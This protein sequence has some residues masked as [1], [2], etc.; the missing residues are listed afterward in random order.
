MTDH[1][2]FKNY[3]L[4]WKNITSCTTSWK[5]QRYNAA[6]P[7]AKEEYNTTEFSHFFFQDRLT[8]AVSQFEV[9]QMEFHNQV[10]NTGSSSVADTFSVLQLA[11]DLV[12]DCIQQLE[13]LEEVLIN[14]YF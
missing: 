6:D 5:I 13:K 14:Q 8:Q 7:S 10:L 4:K 2:P 1:Y 3:G 12:M 9:F 11:H